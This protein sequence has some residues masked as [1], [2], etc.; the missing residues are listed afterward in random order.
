[1]RSTEGCHEDGYQLVSSKLVD[2]MAFYYAVHTRS[3][4]ICELRLIVACVN[5]TRAP[6][7]TIYIPPQYAHPVFTRGGRYLH[8]VWASRSPVIVT[9]LVVVESKFKKQS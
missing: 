8:G 1:M 3:R 2:F 7:S 9:A 4:P 5:H 6:T